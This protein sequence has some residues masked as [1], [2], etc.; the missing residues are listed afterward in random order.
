MQI[1][2]CGWATDG[3]PMAHVG[4]GVLAH[5]RFFPFRTPRVAF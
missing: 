3:A 1:V 2:G 5:R 4:V